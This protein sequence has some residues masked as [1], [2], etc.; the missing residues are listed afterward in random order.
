MLADVTNEETPGAERAAGCIVTSPT[1]GTSAIAAGRALVPAA[2][3]RVEALYGLAGDLGD[4]LEILVQVKDSE[5][6]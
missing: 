5:P 2:S 6:G 3:V 4:D 1:T